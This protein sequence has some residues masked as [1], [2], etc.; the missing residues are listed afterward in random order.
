MNFKIRH[1]NLR[2]KEK[3]NWAWGIF[4]RYNSSQ[5]PKPNRSTSIPYALLPKDHLM[6]V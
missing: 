3:E 2:Q 4:F 5:L 6:M 1:V